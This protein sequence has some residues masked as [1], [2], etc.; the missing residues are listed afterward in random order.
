[1]LLAGTA[2]IRGGVN[3][4]SPLPPNE[5]ECGQRLASAENELARAEAILAV[6]SAQEASAQAAETRVMSLVARL[7]EAKMAAADNGGLGGN[8]ELTLKQ[9]E[10]TNKTASQTLAQ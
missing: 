9:R 4:R 6:Q 2:P 5:A 1:M 8:S 10:K 7:K 3:R